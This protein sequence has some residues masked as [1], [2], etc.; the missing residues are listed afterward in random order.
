MTEVDEAWLENELSSEQEGEETDA[1]KDVETDIVEEV[2][3]T[4]MSLVLETNRFPHIIG[5][6]LSYLDPLSVKRA[7]QVSR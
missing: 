3:K 5:Q 1:V 6:I 7:A 2:E 4:S